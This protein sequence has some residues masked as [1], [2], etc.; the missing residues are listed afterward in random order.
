M[1][2]AVI[3]SRNLAVNN[4]GDYFPLETRQIILGWA[5]GINQ[6][7]RLYAAKRGILVTDYELA[8][9]PHG[10]HAPRQRAL[11]RADVVLVFWDGKSRSTKFVA[12]MCRRIGMAVK[13]YVYSSKRKTFLLLA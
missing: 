8:N 13:L 10:R 1:N 6:S 7:A 2:V 11:R 5:V 3:G 9:K 4:P 12:N